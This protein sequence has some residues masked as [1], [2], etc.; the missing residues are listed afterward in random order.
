MFYI[1]YYLFTSLPQLFA[2]AY[3]CRQTPP[4]REYTCRHHLYAS[5]SPALGTSHL[6]GQAP[7][8]QQGRPA[9]TTAAQSPALQLIPAR[10][11]SAPSSPPT[12]SSQGAGTAGCHLLRHR[13]VIDVDTHDVPLSTGIAPDAHFAGILPDKTP[14]SMVFF[15]CQSFKT[16]KSLAS[17]P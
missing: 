7:A 12:T 1:E 13:P 10:S 17:S 16:P 3:T 5:K 4:P 2:T 9:I 8:G 15:R 11:G 6:S 14:T